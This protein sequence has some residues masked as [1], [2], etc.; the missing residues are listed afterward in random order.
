MYFICI[1]FLQ[2]W[3]WKIKSKHQLWN[4]ITSY[5]LTEVLLFLKFFAFGHP[6]PRDCC[7][8]NMKN[9][10]YLCE[11]SNGYLIL[12]LNP[13]PFH[14]RI[15]TWHFVTSSNRLPWGNLWH[16]LGSMIADPLSDG[17]LLIALDD[18]INP[19]TGRKIFG[20]SHIFNHVAKANQSKYPP[21]AQNVVLV[22]L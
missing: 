9:W 4:K 18:F 7:L 16:T 12:H 6:I 2:V 5:L 14:D 3:F 10:H 13:I 21:W 22:G 17:R 11:I 1:T 15:S 19:K 20:C 8:P